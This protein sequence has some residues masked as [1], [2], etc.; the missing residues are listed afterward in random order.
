MNILRANG[1]SRSRAFAALFEA[2]NR[3]NLLFCAYPFGKTGIPLRDAGAGQRFSIKQRPDGNCAFK[4]SQ[5][6]G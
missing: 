2:E 3:Q 5:A 6:P 4:L 1:M